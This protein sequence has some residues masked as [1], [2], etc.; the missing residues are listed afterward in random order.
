[1]KELEIFKNQLR[2]SDLEKE[3]LKLEQVEC[4]V[5]HDFADGVYI[6]K[7]QMPAGTFAI[8]KRHRFKTYNILLRGKITVFMG[9]HLPVKE[10][11]A[12]CTFISDAG[13]KKMAFFHEDTEWLNIHPTEETDI[14]EIENIFIIP[15]K[16]FLESKIESIESKTEED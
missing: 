15:D 8:G 5:T 12:P 3:C 14:K 11:K 1:M 9:E 10:L 7:T 16:E 6:R 2:I 4:P 13:V